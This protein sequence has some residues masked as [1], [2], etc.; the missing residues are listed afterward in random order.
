MTSR[1]M[2][3]WV[4]ALLGSLCA[5]MGATA[6]ELEKE[7]PLKCAMGRDYWVSAPANIDKQKTYWLFVLVHGYGGN[8][9]RT[10][11]SSGA[12]KDLGDVIFVA[13]SFPNQ[14]Y[15]V[16][17]VGAGKQLVDL[18]VKLKKQY[19]LHDKLFVQGH[20]GGS[21]FSHRFAM[22][23][24]KLV[25]G[26]SASSGGSWGSVNPRAGHI[27]FFLTCGFNDVAKSVS[28]S[29]M[30]RIDWAESYFEQMIKRGNFVKH[31]YWEAGHGGNRRGNVDGTKEVFRLGTTGL[32]QSQRKVVQAE[33][34]RIRQLVADKKTGDALLAAK[35]LVK[36]KIEDLKPKAKDQVVASM[37]KDDRLKLDTQN[38]AGGKSKNG[39]E[40]WINDKHENAEGWSVAPAALRHFTKTQRTWYLKTLSKSLIQ[41]I[42]DEKA[43]A[44]KQAK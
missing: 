43:V 28:S 44:R 26:C 4:F 42:Q 40:Y 1:Q 14:G 19:K 23:Y 37:S 35:G 5:T 11:N 6:A 3:F 21:Q 34:S 39:K 20:S 13:P 18:F 9:G 12:Y 8:G 2:N 32:F 31:R 24:P 30:S 15:Q 33:V 36:L 17:G 41:E 22:T 27:P 38:G 25:V 7:G 29:P 10:I 16:L